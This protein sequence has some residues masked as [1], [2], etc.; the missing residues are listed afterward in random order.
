MLSDRIKRIK[1]SPTLGMVAKA[2][3]L[4]ATGI[5]VVNLS[6]GEPDFDTPDFI[7]AAAIDAIH[8]GFTKYTAADGMP[9]LKK[10]IIEKLKRD[11]QL[12][13]TPSQIV[14]CNGGKQVVFNAFMA[15]INPGDEVIVPAPYWVSYPDIALMFDGV[16]TPVICTHETSFKLTPEALAKAITQKSKWLILNSPSNPTGCVYTAEEL[17]KLADVLRKHPQVNI[18]SDDIYEHLLYEGTTFTNLATLAPD[19]KER[20][21]I[22]NGVSK[23]CSMT[24]WRIGYGAGSATLIKAMGMLQSQS[25]SNACSIAQAAAVAAVNGPHDYLPEWCDTFM[26]RRDLCLEALSHSP[27][28]SVIKPQGAFYLYV[29]C[30]G[31]IGKTTPEGMVI[32][33]DDDFCHYLLQSAHVAVVSGSGFGLSPYFRISYAANRDILL[34]GCHRIVDAIEK[35]R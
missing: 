3:E 26:K 6:A 9:A 30:E 5:D 14:I 8:K 27:E 23:S 10:A 16:V 28:L 1:P 34:Q 21:L 33:S 32:Q 11:N 25:T 12:D 18:L 20:V 29:R 17:G 24:G 4:K 2:N 22:V 35:L 15:T 7:K 19:L 31:V 13:Y